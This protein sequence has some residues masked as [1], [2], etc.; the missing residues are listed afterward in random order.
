MILETIALIPIGPTPEQAE[1][2]ID[3]H[4]IVVVFKLPNAAAGV[5]MLNGMM[6]QLQHSY[7]DLVAILH[8]EDALED[9]EA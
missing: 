5:I 9:D 3:T 2:A 7:A 6:L 8:E 4:N 1:I